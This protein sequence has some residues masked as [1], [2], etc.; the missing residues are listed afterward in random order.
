LEKRGGQKGVR[1]VSGQTGQGTGARKKRKRLE[2]GSKSSFEDNTEKTWT[3]SRFCAKIK[4]GGES[5]KK[6]VFIKAYTGDT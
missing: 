6:Q 5:G 4:K 2:Q 1:M 3:D